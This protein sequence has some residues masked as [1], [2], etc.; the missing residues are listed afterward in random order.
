MALQD[1]STVRPKL[2][3]VVGS[4][5][6]YRDKFNDVT[7]VSNVSLGC[8]APIFSS[9]HLYNGY[10]W[11]VSGTSFNTVVL[12]S[13]LFQAK[14]NNLPSAPQFMFFVSGKAEQDPTSF[15]NEVDIFSPCRNS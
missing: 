10:I 7:S 8:I 15:K 9:N 14:Y 4:G 12:N 1:E 11:V 3:N 2:L 6:S 13:A 5:L